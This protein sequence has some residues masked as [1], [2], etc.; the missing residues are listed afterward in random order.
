LNSL[1]DDF[2]F[3]VDDT[4]RHEELTDESGNAKYFLPTHF[5]GRVTKKVEVTTPEGT[6]ETHV[7]FDP[8]EQSFDVA[9]VYYKYWSMANDYNHKVKILPEMELAK[10]MIEKRHATKR[11]LKGN[12]ITRTSS[13]ISGKQRKGSAVVINH[14]QLADQVHDWFMMCVYGQTENDAGKLG[15]MDLGKFVQFL[16]KYTAINLLGVNFIAGV[17]NIAISETLE[18][19]EGIAKEYVDIKDWVKADKWYLG[20]LRGTLG[21]VGARTSHNVSTKLY[22]WLGVLDDYGTADMNRKTR[23]GQLMKS[24]TLFFTS[25]AGEH[26]MQNRFAIAMLNNLRAIDNDG[27]DIG[28]MLDMV[29]L[30]SKGN[31]AF[32][33]RVN[34]EKSKWTDKD[35]QA[36]KQKTRGVLSRINGEYSKL[37]KVAIERMA[38]GRMAY[39]FRKFIV[40]GFRRRWGRENYYE[41]LGQFAE[42][43]YIT[44]GK[45]MGNIGGKIFGKNEEN[46]EYDF[47]QRLMSNLQSFKMS[48]VGEEWA[49]L[50]DHEKANIVRTVSEVG[51]LVLAIIIANIAM[52]MRGGT[53]DPDEERFWSFI[54][55]QAYR[56]QNEIMF[57]T[58]KL[59]SAMSILRSPAASISVVE[60]IIKLTGQIFHPMAIYQNGTWKG[61]PKIFKTL[62]NMTPVERQ[63]YRLR[64]VT[65][66]VTWVQNAAFGGGGGGMA[67]P[68]Q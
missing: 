55:Y 37:G 34:R 36:F 32:D 41:R 15:K 26:Y 4:H 66:Q 53:D 16:N 48:M 2:T 52:G 1:K 14:T 29:K 27:K 43:D 18:R 64:D 39:M 67:V 28:S 22:E 63:Y 10:F 47:L 9:G 51:F 61:R 65:D 6:K 17:A 24:D 58:P 30:D 3:R 50:S 60:N 45:F 19:I 7:V 42:G 40:P 21:D 20:H 49:S 11:D 46:S 56:L 68:T 62:M 5:T 38:V 44:T 12:I 59:D 23:F 54:A 35:I 31:L 8:E 25:K 13:T 57:F 33:P